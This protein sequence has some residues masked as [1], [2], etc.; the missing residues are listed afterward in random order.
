MRGC[1]WNCRFCVAGSVYKP[2]RKKDPEAL[3]EEIRA[4]AG[5][6]VGLIAP[7]L[8]DYPHTRDILCMDGVDFSITS[9]RANRKSAE[10]VRF[11]KGHKSVSIAPEAG[12]QRL[13]DVIDKRITEENIIETCGLILS[14]EIET[15][16][17]YFM[18]GLPT[19]DERDV[20]GIISLVKK[21]RGG[22]SRGNIVLTL[23]TFVPKPFTPFQWHP[24]E[25]M[26]VIKTRLKSVKKDLGALQ[27]V[28]VFHDVPKY[29]YMQGLFARGDR[30]IS[31]VLE[32]MQDTEDW[33][34]ACGEVGMD[35]DFV[36]FRQREFHEILPWDFIDND[37]AKEKLW[38][39]YQKALSGT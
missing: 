35:A 27:G 19:E 28:R 15:L 7:S 32:R 31:M 14:G 20:E 8:S 23:S 29:A 39:E 11:L 26:E 24:M 34:K 9:L 22:S 37:I 6:R 10:L 2:V 16:R 1:P 13:R 38:A 25:R 5:R 18:V 36:L 12:T 17:L 4:R 30:R 3:K 21:I 33:R